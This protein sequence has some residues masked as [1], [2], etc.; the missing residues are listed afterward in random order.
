MPVEG[1]NARLAP[2]A[3]KGKV[4]LAIVGGYEQ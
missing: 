4:E 1:T 3:T 2:S